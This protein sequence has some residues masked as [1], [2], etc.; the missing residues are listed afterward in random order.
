MEILLDP[1][2]MRVEV[3][4]GDRHLR[5]DVRDGD[6]THGPLVRCHDSLEPYRV[7]REPLIVLRA[8]KVVFRRLDV[9]PT[10]PGPLP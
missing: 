5:K 10:D 3:D 8:L 4:K 7:L 1:D 9:P 6:T 2:P